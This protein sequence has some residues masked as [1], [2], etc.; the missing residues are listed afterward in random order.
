MVAG[1]LSLDSGLMRAVAFLALFVISIAACGGGGAS[2]TTSATPSTGA[3]AATT[4][5]SPTTSATA[6]PATT[7]STTEPTTTTAPTTT[8]PG[9]ATY[10]FAVTGSTVEG[11]DRI[12]ASVGEEIVIVVAADVADEVHLHGYDLYADV[13]P[14]DSATLEVVTD[15][16]GIF[17]MELEGARLVLTELV[18]R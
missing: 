14:G 8:D 6:A 10:E 5:P 13:G 18:V 16:P 11:P 9:P 2:S 1:T 15:I 12:E 4:T 7:T 17:E 3:P